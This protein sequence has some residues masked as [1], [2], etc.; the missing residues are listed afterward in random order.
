LTDSD[1][2]DRCSDLLSAPDNFD[3]AINQAT[4][5]LEHKIRVKSGNSDGLTG[6]QLVNAV[7]KE[8]LSQTVLITSSDEGEHRGIVSICRGL[9]MAFR[10]ASHHQLTA[11]I[12]RE[13]ALKVVGFIDEIVQIVE[14]STLHSRP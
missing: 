13:E 11:D 9:M 5:V 8:D 14:K 3:R 12:T 4:Q 2:K 1:I 10:N 7:L 6:V